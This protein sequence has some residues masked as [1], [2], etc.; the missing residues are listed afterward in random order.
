MHGSEFCSACSL[1]RWR[2]TR[3]GRFVPPP[4][5]TFP[6]FFPAPPSRYAII[7]ASDFLGRN[8]VCRDCQL[9]RSTSV[10]RLPND[11]ARARRYALCADCHRQRKE[12]KLKT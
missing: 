10:Y 4:D 11:G 1:T 12:G 6:N 8:R 5:V 7:E 9:A 2:G 3:P